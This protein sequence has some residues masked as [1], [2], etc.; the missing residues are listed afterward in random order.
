MKKEVLNL[1]ERSR[2][3]KIIRRGRRRNYGGRSVNTLIS[4]EA[5]T[6][7]LSFGIGLL[8]NHSVSTLSHFLAFLELRESD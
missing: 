3:G 5:E 7:I 8:A 2:V 1:K 6:L 4:K